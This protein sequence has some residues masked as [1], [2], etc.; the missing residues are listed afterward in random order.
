[1]Y[2][3]LIVVPLTWCS[4]WFMCRLCCC[5]VVRQMNLDYCDGLSPLNS[6]QCVIAPSLPYTQSKSLWC[7]PW[8]F[9]NSALYATAVY[10]IVFL[11]CMWY[12]SFV[13]PSMCHTHE[14]CQNIWTYRQTW[15]QHTSRPT[16]IFLQQATCKISV[17]S[18]LLGAPN[19]LMKNCDFPSVYHYSISYVCRKSCDLSDW[20]VFFSDVL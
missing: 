13:C 9:M 18:P 19:T 7:E 1:M 4:C 5:A 3:L 12:C 2:Y 14:A 8:V 17:Q 20:I 11:C 15:L 10:D 6:S 16:M